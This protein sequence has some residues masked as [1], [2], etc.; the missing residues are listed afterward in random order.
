MHEN[1]HSSNRKIISHRR[2]RQRAKRRRRRRK[3]NTPNKPS[4]RMKWHFGKKAKSSAK[5]SQPLHNEERELGITDWKTKIVCTLGPASSSREVIEEMVKAGMDVVRINFSH[6]KE[7]ETRQLFALIRE[8]G[9][10]FDEQV[11]FFVLHTPSSFFSFFH[12]LLFSLS[13]LG[14][15]KKKESKSQ[16]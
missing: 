15:R 11:H 16:N 3:L 12:I 6:A 2:Q 13:L 10:Q 5:I 1:I 7:A 9:A 14:T 4:K 8:I